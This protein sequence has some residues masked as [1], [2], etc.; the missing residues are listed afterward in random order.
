MKNSQELVE[1]LQKMMGEVKSFINENHPEDVGVVISF[2]YGE[3]VSTYIG[4]VGINILPIAG[5]L[6]DD[7]DFRNMVK[8][9]KMHKMLQMMEEK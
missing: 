5:Q 9:H 3:R 2:S 1:N 7:P 6:S 8:V 4:G